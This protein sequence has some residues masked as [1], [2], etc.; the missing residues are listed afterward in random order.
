MLPAIAVGGVLG[1]GTRAL[2]LEVF[3]TTSPTWFLLAVNV[4]GCAVL[5]W[6]AT[7]L[8]TLG[9][10]APNARRRL[11]GLSSGF[12]GSLTT[13][14]TLA[15]D[16]AQYLRWGRPSNALPPLVASIVVGGLAVWVGHRIASGQ[17][18]TAARPST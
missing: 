12:C 17:T 18:S 1:A 4:A 2:I 3:T 10:T 9:P 11:L 8:T 14:S 13:F 7:M 16:T 15:V 6:A 5:G